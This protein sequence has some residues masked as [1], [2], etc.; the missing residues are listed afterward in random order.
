MFWRVQGETSGMKWV[1]I[2]EQIYEW[3]TLTK[4]EQVRVGLGRNWFYFKYGIKDT[5]VHFEYV[6]R[7][8]R[9]AT[10]VKIE[11]R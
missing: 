3:V 9:I 10:L 11:I 5:A 1:N 2:A 7:K 4:R 6:L 8:D